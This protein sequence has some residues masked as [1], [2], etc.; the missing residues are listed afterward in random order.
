MAVATGIYTT[1]SPLSSDQAWYHG[2]LS[3]VKA[4]Q[5]LTTFGYDCFLVRVTEGT[6]ILSLIHHGHLHHVN[7]KYGPGWYELEND[8]ALYSFTELEE[9][10]SH[11]SSND[12]GELKATLGVACDKNTSSKTI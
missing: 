3:R 4:E 9:L 2:E 1:S 11:Y 12:I 5:A 10:V 7:I 8:S 6:L